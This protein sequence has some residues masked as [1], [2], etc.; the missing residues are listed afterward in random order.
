VSKKRN[1][2]KLE[3]W[4]KAGRRYRLSHE[5]VQMAREL[6]LSPNKLGS[7]ANHKHEPWK[8]PLREF[9]EHLYFKRFGR[10]RPEPMR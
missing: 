4:A 7:L 3:A 2:A 6:G 10:E 5:H 9:I 8:S 1:A